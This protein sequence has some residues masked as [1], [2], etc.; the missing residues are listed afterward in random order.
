VMD[1]GIA[2]SVD[3][4]ETATTGGVAGTPE[5]MSPEQVEGSELDL[6]SDIYSLGVVLY[7][8]ATGRLPFSGETP[9]SVAVKHKIETPP[10]PSHFKPHI[11]SG[12]N[13]LIMK[14]LEKDKEK[15]YQD[16]GQLSADLDKLIAAGNEVEEKKGPEKKRKPILLF[17]GG[18]VVV[19]AALFVFFVLFPRKGVLP[20]ESPQAPAMVKPL[21]TE[22]KPPAAPVVTEP[23]PKAVIPIPGEN[24]FQKLYSQA[25]ELLD[26]GDLDGADRAVQAAKK[27]NLTFEL[28]VLEQKVRT[29]INARNEQERKQAEEKRSLETRDDSTFEM[30]RR[31]DTP[32]AA[33]S[34]K[35]TAGWPSSRLRDGRRRS[36]PPDKPGPIR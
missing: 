33:M 7:E 3:A 14:C 32:R 35:P 27:V 25:E 22:V 13:R 1:F 21:Q 23:K 18:A 29:Q 12:L 11:S 6:R 28:G 16:V 24:D 8:M 4:G 9:L 10:S 17:V 26:R 19:L 36:L 30:A 34:L 2:R 20:R 5:Y 15:R 31:L